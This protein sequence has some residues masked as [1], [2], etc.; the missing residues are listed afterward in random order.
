MLG[1]LIKHE[2]K[3]S[4]RYIM[5]IYACAV[6][7]MLFVLLAM[8]TKVAW[9]S[10]VGSVVLYI[11][12]LVSIVMTLVSIIKNFYDSLYGVQGYLSF[13]LPVKCSSL[14]FSKIIMSFFW[15]IASFLIMGL[16]ILII[17]L[18]AKK[19]A[20]GTLDGMWDTIKMSGILEILPSGKMMIEYAAVILLVVFLAI[21]TFIG[22][23]YFSVTVANTRPLQNH[24]KI[25]GFIIFFASY[26]ITNSIG[27]KL[28]YSFPLAVNISSDKL[29]IT[30]KAMENSQALMSFGLAGTIFNALVAVGLLVATG[31]IMEHKVNIK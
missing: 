23:V 7:M 4:A 28:T 15:V 19:Q 18:N 21:L 27:A 3:H 24:P 14:L 26:G 5:T 2:F 20:D 6:A 25:F 11:V 13:T 30:L 29:A 9:I 1:K 12:G 8:F 17:T 31:Y 16:S 22:F 10:I